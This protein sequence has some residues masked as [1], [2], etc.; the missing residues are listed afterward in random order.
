MPEISV[1]MGVYNC[2]N[3]ELLRKSVQSIINQTFT[4]WELVICDDGST[5]NTLSHLNE[6][7]KLDSRIKI[8][9]YSQNRG[10]HYALN[11]CFQN[12]SGRYI[13][14]QDDDDISYPERFQRELDFLNKNNDY[15]FVGTIADVYDEKG[16]WGEYKVDPYPD[17]NSFLWSNPFMHPTIMIRRDVL[18]KV[19]GYRVA[20]ETRRC[21]DYD[22]FMRLYA[23][24]YQGCNIQEKLYKYWI[25]QNNKTKYRP[26]KYRVDEAIVR[27][28]GYKMLGILVK[29]IPYIIKP[30]LIGLLPQRIFSGI[31]EK[32]YTG[33]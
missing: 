1:I 2:K 5:D 24:G 8:L 32:Q 22:L 28:K 33:H 21:E 14:R 17:K 12:S 15:D 26:M 4:D 23:N 20:K 31:R 25:Q 9:S 19:G 18:T 6:L 30:V 3:T 10:L 7:S 13:A 16:I 27:F 29:G 11:Y